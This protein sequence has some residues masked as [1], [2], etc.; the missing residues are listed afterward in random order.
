MEICD[1]EVKQRILEGGGKGGRVDG[2]K[3]IHRKM[4]KLSFLSFGN[5]ALKGCSCYR[6]RSN[7]G[8]FL[9][10]VKGVGAR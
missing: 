9:L 3:R 7:K 6:E 2:V 4:P 8:D 10:T 1:A 5:L